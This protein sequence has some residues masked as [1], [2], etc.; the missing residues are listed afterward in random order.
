MEVSEV[1]VEEPH[2]LEALI[3]SGAPFLLEMVVMDIHG[4]L[5]IHR[6]VVVV[7]GTTRLLVLGLMG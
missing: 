2:K 6:M 5:L 7:L 3:I 4:Q 1:G